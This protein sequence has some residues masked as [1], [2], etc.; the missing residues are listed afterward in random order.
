[1]LTTVVEGRVYD[2]SHAVG[3][4]AAAGDGFNFPCSI[5]MAS[6]GMLYIV[7]RGSENNFGSRVTKLYVGAPGEEKVQGEFCRYGTDPGRALWPNSVA[8]DKQGNVYVSDDWLNRISAFDQDGNFLNV[9]GTTGSGQGQLD[10]PAGL[11]FDKDDNLYVVDSRNHRIQVFSK[12]GRFL[13]SCGKLG[14]GPVEFNMPWGIHIDANDDV[15]VADWKNNRIQKL[16]KTGA[17]LLELQGEGARA[18]NHPT[19][20]TTD[21]DGDI[22][23]CDWANHKLRIY[24]SEG[25]LIT[26]LL[27]DAQVMS[28]WGQQSLNANPDMV[29]MR[30]RVKHMERE[31][32]F[33]YP[34]A[35]GYDQEQD[36]ILVADSQRGRLQ[37]YKKDKNYSVPQFNL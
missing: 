11:A 31:W 35:V 29:K 13:A 12:D 1:M 15:F 19:H 18:L 2:W 23:V 17:W 36:T 32:R 24:N 5:A 3:R 22:Y 34:A 26:S 6:E 21:P 33:C 28:K 16:T 9:W 8:L 25:D 7:S 4:N 37:I 10:G 27:G 20:V 14:T 30:R